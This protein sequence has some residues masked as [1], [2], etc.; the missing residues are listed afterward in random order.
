MVPVAP[1]SISCDVRPFPPSHPHSFFGVIQWPGVYPPFFFAR[2]SAACKSGLFSSG[3]GHGL[4]FCCSWF[5]FP[6]SPTFLFR[7]SLPSFFDTSIW[8]RAGSVFCTRSS[9]SPPRTLT[10]ASSFPWY[11]RVLHLRFFHPSPL[12]PWIAILSMGAMQLC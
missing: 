4:P 9:F 1:F 3:V 8:R 11:D 7:S 5:I 2:R 6:P 10:S 12:L